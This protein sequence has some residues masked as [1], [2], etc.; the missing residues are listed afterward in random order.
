MASPDPWTA[1]I[2]RA[3][4]AV[5]TGRVTQVVGLTVRAEGP[6]VP[7]GELCV[8]AGQADTVPAEVVGFHRHETWLMPLGPMAGLGPDAE[9]RALGHPLTVVGGAGVLGRLL[10]GIGRPRDGGPPIVGPAH[11][12]SGQARTP[13]ARLPVAEPLWTGVRLWDGCLT[14]G[15]GQRVG[16]FAGTGVGKTTL[17]RM[18][19]RGASAD[20][21]VVALVGERGREVAEFWRELTPAARRRTVVVAATSD[22]SPL[23]RVR[24]AETATA[25]A[26][27]FQREGFRVLLVMDSLTRAAMAQREVGTAVG[28]PPTAR[29]YTPSVFAWLPR[30]LERAGRFRT[31]AI[32]GCYTVLMD[33][34]DLEA[35]PV[36]DAVRGVLDGHIVLDRKRAE[37]GW[38]PAVDLPRSL[39]RTMDRVVDPAHREAAA[40]A[41]AWVARAAEVKDLVDLGAYQPGADPATDEALQMV[42]RFNAWGVQGPDEVAAPEETRASLL[43]LA[44]EVSA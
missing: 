1:A 39:S 40:R 42:G 17:L 27:G 33:G 2:K 28:E 32:T 26:E 35:D 30:L 25:L 37:G 23:L 11:A 29:G 15:V 43:A 14:M 24:A 4:R 16:I 41:R 13:L 6:R 31:G 12:V 34:D 5:P 19:V 10:D 18:L 21:V 7:V 20:V 22:E 9:V 36:A 3:G 38:Y 44:G 8:I